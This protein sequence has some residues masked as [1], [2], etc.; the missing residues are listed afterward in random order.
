MESRVR[1]IPNQEIFSPYYPPQKRWWMPLKKLK[2]CR[3]L[4][5]GGHVIA[6]NLVIAYDVGRDLRS[7]DRIKRV[8]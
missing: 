8:G 3:Q 1:L 6:S 4:I 5:F 2:G 7:V